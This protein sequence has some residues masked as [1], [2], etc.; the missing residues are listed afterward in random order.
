M[1]IAVLFHQLGP[2]HV[3]R[4]KAAARVTDVIAVE[5]SEKTQEYAWQH[6]DG[7]SAFERITLTHG[8]DIRNLSRSEMWRRIAQG[9]NQARPDVIAVHGYAVPD[10][11]AAIR[12]GS[13]T[14][15]PM[16]VMSE[17]TAHDESRAWWKEAVKRRVIAQFHAALVGGS[18]H[19]FYLERL[20]MPRHHIFTGYDVVDNLHFATGAYAARLSEVEVRV[21]LH[22]PEHY[23]LA[24]SRFIEKKNL[25]RLI[26]AFALYRERAGRQAWHLVLLGDGPLRNR[27]EAAVAAYGLEEGV[28]LPGFKQYE[29]LPAYYGLANAFVHASTVEQWGLVVNEAMAAGLPVLVS[30]RCGCALDLVEQGRNGYTFDPYDTEA[31]ATM[32]QHMASDSCDC[33]GMGAASRDI[34]ARWTPETFALSMEQAAT[35][36]LEVARPKRKYMGEMLISALM[37]R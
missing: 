22:L 3:A 23:F 30:D 21:R 17:S 1:R 29:E 25:D 19:V 11:L 24:S 27:V 6:V 16:I 2:Y 13:Q 36:A 31:L 14:Y 10:A 18:P 7:G 26:R 15:T 28:H 37:H 5:L 33:D 35:I 8:S 20:G 32:M 34:I 9:L 4:L 12:W